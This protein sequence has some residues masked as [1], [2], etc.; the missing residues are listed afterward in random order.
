MTLKNQKFNAGTLV[1]DVFNRFMVVVPIE[2]KDEANVAFGM[3]KGFNKMGGKP[4][5]LYTDDE[6][7]FQKEAVNTYLEEEEGIQHHKT[8][9]HANHSER[10]IR[11][12]KDMLY[13]RVEADEKDR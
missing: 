13:I 9:A 3:I 4:K 8:R 12:F 5:I 2:G 11:N 1:I 6:G 10:A 7:A